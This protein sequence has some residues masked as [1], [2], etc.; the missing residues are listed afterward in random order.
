MKSSVEQFFPLVTFLFFL[1]FMKQ[2]LSEIFAQQARNDVRFVNKWASFRLHSIANVENAL[3]SNLV[4]FWTKICRRCKHI[5]DLIFFSP[6]T[7]MFSRLTI[8]KRIIFYFKACSSRASL[9]VNSLII[10]LHVHNH[11]TCL[12]FRHKVFILSRPPFGCQS[13]KRIWMF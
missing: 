4:K 13:V 6:G 3:C 7:K 10:S 8:P 5:F 2:V 9:V 11:F 1:L 12:T